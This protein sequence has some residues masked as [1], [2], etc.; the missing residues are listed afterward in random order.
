MVET[1][2]KAT[3]DAKFD[4]ISSDLLAANVL[5]TAFDKSGPD[6]IDGLKKM[7]WNISRKTFDDFYVLCGPTTEML[8]FGDLLRMTLLGLTYELVIHAISNQQTPKN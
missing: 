5:K 4:F 6:L 3:K 1:I 8:Q 7:R 2:S